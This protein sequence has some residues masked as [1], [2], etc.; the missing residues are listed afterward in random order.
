MFTI[1]ERLFTIQAFT[2]TRVHCNRD[3]YLFQ[4]G[5]GEPKVK[6]ARKPQAAKNGPKKAH[7]CDRDQCESS[8]DR[9]NNLKIHIDKYSS[10]RF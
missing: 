2:I 3:I 10:S 6:L 5:K 1:N 7:S 9:P 4:I 8:F